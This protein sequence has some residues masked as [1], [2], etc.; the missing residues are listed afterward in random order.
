[1][2]SRIFRYSEKWPNLFYL[3]WMTFSDKFLLRGWAGLSE[4][5]AQYW[6][7]SSCG[8]MGVSRKLWT[9][10]EGHRHETV[11]N[12]WSSRCSKFAR[13]IIVVRRRLRKSSL[14]TSTQQ[15]IKDDIDEYCSYTRFGVV[16]SVMVRSCWRATDN[17]KNFSHSTTT[18]LSASADEPREQRRSGSRSQWC[19]QTRT[20]RATNF[21]EL[22]WQHLRR[23]TCHG[24]RKS[25]LSSDA[26]K[27]F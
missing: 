16:S 4:A 11:E 17:D 27:R 26:R 23:S 22:S 6:Q 9:W 5:V 21:V 8:A 24:E 1:V 12:H 13:A 7:I 2:L 19:K 10:P 25:R 15:P 20:L 3:S 14:G 18:Q